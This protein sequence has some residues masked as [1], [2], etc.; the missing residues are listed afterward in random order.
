MT[1]QTPGEQPARV[2]LALSGGGFRASLFHIGVLARLADL[3]LLREVQVIS[4]V[5]G[6]SI[7]GALYYLHVR[8]LL[9]SKPDCDIKPGDYVAIVAEIQHSF[10][11]AIRQNLRMRTFADLQKN[12]RMYRRDYSRS[13]RMA[14]LY[15]EHLYAPLVEPAALQNGRVALP[16]LTIQ[17]PDEP[18]GFHPFV[19][20]GSGTAPNDRRGSKVPVLVVNATTLNTGHNFQFTATWLGEPDNRLD[21]GNLDHNLRLRRAY[22]LRDAVEDKYRALPLGVAVAASAAVPG[23]FPPL[24]LTDLYPDLTPQL[25]DGGVHDNQGIEG[26]LDLRCTHLIVSDACGQ[27]RDAS[28]PETRTPAVLKRSNDTLMDRV[29]EA[30]FVAASALQRHGEI[31]HLCFF[32]M[33]QDMQQPALTWIGGADK[34]GQVEAVHGRTAYGVDRQTQ[35]ALARLRTDLDAFTEVEST[36]LMA[37][38]YLIARHCLDDGLRKGLGHST[39]PARTHEW[40]FLAIEPYLRDREVDPAFLSQLEI[41]AATVGKSLRLLRWLRVLAAA[42]SGAAALALLTAL[43]ASRGGGVLY[44]GLVGIAV[45]LGAAVAYRWGWR[46]LQ[47]VGSRVPTRLSELLVSPVGALLALAVIGHLRT[48]TVLRLRC[49]ALAALRRP[50]RTSTPP[51][52]RQA[53]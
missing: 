24:A 5:S 26:L 7:I 22:Y 9:Q 18:P 14:E 37:D 3:D 4:T 49:G 36:A 43:L 32:H 23:I 20:G 39:A 42:G 29:R 48:L 47:A 11:L 27:M 12:L 13:D 41:G 35:E 25:V 8:R 53:A 21:Q 31:A 51:A 6:G 40:P 44:A 30:Q 45:L 33:K 34:P 50:Q 2:G 19:D 52:D 17:P 15:E 16:Q 46:L 38:G 1:S 28:E 10:P